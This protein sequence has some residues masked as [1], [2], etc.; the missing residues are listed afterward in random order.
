[1]NVA[2]F[3]LG[4]VGSVSAACLAEL[5]HNVYGVDVSVDKVDAIREGRSPVSEA[6][7]E[8]LLRAGVQNRRL[9]SG[10]EAS[11]AIERSDVSLVCVGTPGRGNG[12]LDF[13]LLE[14]AL[15]GIGGELRGRRE[16]HV[17]VIRS[18]VLP[19]SVTERFVPLLE[20]ESG[21]RAGAD[22][23]V[24]VNPEFLREGTAVADFR[25][26]PFTVIGQWDERSGDQVAALYAGLSA[27]VVRVR[28][29]E[30]CML[31]YASN[32]FHA[33]KVAFA[34]EIGAFCS[35][36]GVDSH[37]VMSLFVRD[38]VLNV[39][40]AYLAPGFAFGG[41]CLPKDLRALLY[42]AKRGDLEL[43]VLNAVLPSND[44]HIRR[45]VDLI[46]AAGSQRVGMLGLS[47]KA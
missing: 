3:G 31:K 32:A 30:A 10:N 35:L 26:P 16:Y 15:R 33:L 41:S 6:G 37:V 8:E 14:A 24:C 42:A 23:G 19:G 4:Y 39:S 43:P 1:M 36:M 45:A 22:F 7:L 29:D 47:F 5:G 18:T 34:N 17:V 12:S 27:P 46:A 28:V 13:G 2:V 9:E 25:C 21:K 40:K 38:T 11:A 44:E 20:S